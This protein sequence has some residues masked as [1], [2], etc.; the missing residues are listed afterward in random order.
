MCHLYNPMATVRFSPLSL[1][2]PPL[3][4][5]PRPRPRPRS[6]PRPPFPP[7][8]KPQPRELPQTRCMKTLPHQLRLMF[9][10]HGLSLLP[11]IRPTHIVSTPPTPTF[12]TILIIST[13][14]KVTRMSAW[15]LSFK[16]LVR[17]QPPACVSSKDFP[18]SLAKDLP[19][20]AQ[21]VQTDVALKHLLRFFRIMV[22]LNTLPVA[23]AVPTQIQI[24]PQPQ[25][26]R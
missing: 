26:R 9:R 13:L 7:P 8:L 4:S 6:C 20:L 3:Q 17:R 23:A 24:Q 1:P 22:A 2:L 19:C 11:A 12:L 16:N 25:Q 14:S 18:G 15:A 10:T 21:A 5:H